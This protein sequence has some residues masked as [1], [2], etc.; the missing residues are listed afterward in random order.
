MQSDAGQLREARNL[1]Q[2]QEADRDYEGE[3]IPA[4]RTPRAP[5]AIGPR[6]S[7]APTVPSGNRLIAS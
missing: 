7:M 1:A 6:N 3:K 4:D 5:S 2:S